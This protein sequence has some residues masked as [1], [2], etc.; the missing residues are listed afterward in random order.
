MASSG[1][2][3]A[4]LTR[5]F[6][7]IFG[8]ALAA[9]LLLTGAPTA[10]ADHGEWQERQAWIEPVREERTRLIPGRWTNERV[11][12]PPRTVTREETIT[13]EVEVDYQYYVND[14]Y[15]DLVHVWV[16][17]FEVQCRT[18]WKWYQDC[19]DFWGSCEWVYG[20]REECKRVDVSYFRLE[21]RW[22]DTSY[23]ETRTRTEYRQETRI[24]T[25]EIPGYWDVRRRWVPG[26]TET[27]WHIV[28]PGRW[29]TTQVW[30]E[31]PHE[32]ATEDPAACRPSGIYKV[33]SNYVGNTQ[34]TDEDGTI[35]YG[36]ETSREENPWWAV[37]L[38]SASKGN[39][40][41]YDSQAFNGRGRGADGLL[42]AGRFYRN[43]L[44][45]GD[46]FEP[47]S[48][49]FFQD[50]TVVAGDL[51]EPG[52]LDPTPTPEIG[53]PTPTPSPTP[54][55]T[56]TPGNP[57]SSPTASPTATPTR[58][59]TA[60]P[61]S[62]TQPPIPLDPAGEFAFAVAIE[63]S[64]AVTRLGRPSIQVLRGAPVEV[65]LLPRLEPPEQDPDATVSFRSW[66]Y[67]SG[68][69]DH[70][71]APAAGVGHGPLQ[72]LRL[73]LDTRPPAGRA[74]HQLELSARVRVIAGDG[75]VA[76]F[77]LPVTLLAQVHYQ[78]IA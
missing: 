28:E 3:N 43:Y 64:G 73:R 74:Q 8:I 45:D 75:R 37:S 59:P 19:S 11:W 70:P 65:Y 41:R 46:C 16:E 32:G 4:S 72:P 47:A 26:R 60:P 54:A 18:V 29:E 22:V 31:L 2:L 14:G 24:S 9:L 61:L 13:V 69:N 35:H 76:D 42:L 78:A 55:A 36:T 40:S 30:V 58:R 38:G 33:S 57:P 25:E 5:A 71:E 17:A 48:I 53:S 39:S 10:L 49:V 68:R 50:D 44:P 7:G 6:S 52:S 1:D 20:P 62:P 51:D 67:L 15:W 12:V 63:G 23:W 21:R 34:W 56:P 66:T 77:E 27:Y